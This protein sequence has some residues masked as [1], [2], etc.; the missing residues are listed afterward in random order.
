MRSKHYTSWNTAETRNAITTATPCTCLF[1][2]KNTAINAIIFYTTIKEF[3]F[4][5]QFTHEIFRVQDKKLAD[6]QVF[7]RTR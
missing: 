3:E 1:R 2:G 5:A 7:S 6:G 4:N